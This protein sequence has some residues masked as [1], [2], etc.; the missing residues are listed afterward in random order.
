MQRSDKKYYLTELGVRAYDSI[1]NNM[2]SLTFD[3]SKK[4]YNSFLLKGLMHLTP[5]RIMVANNKPNL[6]VIS[7]SIIILILGGIFCALNELYPFFLLFG[8]I[9]EIP[10]APIFNFLFFIFNFFVFFYIIEAICRIFYK[11]KEDSVKFLS[12]FTVIFFPSVLY[13]II[14]Y[15]FLFFKIIE[16]NFIGIMDNIIMIIFQVWSLW[17]LTYSITTYKRLK[18]EN[19][20]II[21]LLLHYGG[22]SIILMISI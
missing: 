9:P 14:H 7:F 18:I 5:K 22:F 8:T 1:R 16:M 12:T 15:T 19:S 17:L 2:G 4:D 10:Y 20:L 13:L 11:K 6:L 21:S 3:I